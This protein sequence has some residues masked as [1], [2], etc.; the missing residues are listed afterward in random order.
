MRRG[1]G[2]I[3]I[4]RSIC[5]CKRE[6]SQSGATIGRDYSTTP[7]ELKRWKGKEVLIPQP[8]RFF[9]APWS[10]P[11]RTKVDLGLLRWQKPLQR[12]GRRTSPPWSCRASGRTG[13]KKPTTRRISFPLAVEASKRKTV[14]ENNVHGSD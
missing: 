4:T 10:Q 8:I 5:I 13:S 7:V 14:A 12:L 9:L 2:A 11:R 1:K 6:S 3:F